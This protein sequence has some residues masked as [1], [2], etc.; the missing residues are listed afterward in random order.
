MIESVT[1]ALIGFSVF[2]AAILLVVYLFFMNEVSKTPMSRAS[3][4][5]LL[6]VLAALQWHHYSFLSAG[7]SLV[8]SR[9]YIALLLI[10]PTA[11]FFFSRSVLQRD[12]YFSLSDVLHFL[13]VLVGVWVPS[14]VAV[15]VAFVVGAGYSVWF[16]QMVFGMRDQSHRFK[17]ERFFFTTFAVLA[18]AVLIVGLSV[19]YVSLTAFHVSY[20]I[21]I[22][23]GLLLVVSALLAYPGL[24]NDITDAAAATYAKSSLGAID[25]DVVAS[26]LDQLM[27]VDRVY[28]D[29]GLT[30]ATTAA[31]LEITP[32]QLS[33]LVNTHHAVGFPRYVRK[34]KIEEAC[35]LLTN[36]ESTILAISMDTGFQS[37]SSFYAAF[38]EVMG[39]SPGQYR[40]QKLA[41]KQP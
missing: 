29:E 33:E 4:T 11:F 37:Q 39:T 6:S 8:N 1:V 30:L 15:N 21:S 27:R 18:V 13:P 25:V 36:S 16:A 10:A 12:R 7:T 17:H 23:V 3:S 38:R 22:G 20:S 9:I 24:A 5:T 41:E 28:R 35:E 14:S 26:R 2:S 32:H 19:P 31:L 34:F 40:R